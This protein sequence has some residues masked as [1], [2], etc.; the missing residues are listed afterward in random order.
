MKK[1]F[2][3]L[4]LC[5]YALLSCGGQ[6]GLSPVFHVDSATIAQA[7]SI[8]SNN[9]TAFSQAVLDV[10]NSYRATTAY[11]DKLDPITGSMVRVTR[12]QEQKNPLA[13][14]AQL[15]STASQHSSDVDQGRFLISLKGVTKA[16]VKQA[17]PECVKENIPYTY[18][19]NSIATTIYLDG[20]CPHYNPTTQK[21]SW[22]RVDDAGISNNGVGEVIVGIPILDFVN[23]NY[24][25]TLLAKR[26]V[27]E[28]MAS[29]SHKE[30]ILDANSGP[31]V[32]YAQ[33]S[34]VGF[35]V[36]SYYGMII[37]TQ[38]FIRN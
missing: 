36:S 15:T 9:P 21:T 11:I 22:M 17:R 20:I 35:Y 3:A 16:M 30:V 8:L 1:A 23:M 25:T 27:G 28:W 18:K 29:S 34:G 6:S 26:V 32:G 19:L 38:I 33:E 5:S 14:N 12:V 24:D 31:S 2:I 10:V 13:Y 4:V 7:S 37:V